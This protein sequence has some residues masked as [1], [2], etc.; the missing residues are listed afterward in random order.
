ML[1][2]NNTQ[3]MEDPYYWRNKVLS[4]KAFN[5]SKNLNSKNSSNFKWTEAN[6]KEKPQ[7]KNENQS[8][9]NKLWYREGMQIDLDSKTAMAE[10]LKNIMSH[11]KD[12][13]A[14][15][16]KSGNYDILKDITDDK[17]KLIDDQE[18][19]RI[20]ALAVSAIAEA[21]G[22][23]PDAKKILDQAGSEQLKKLKI[24]TR[25]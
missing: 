6:N 8:A 21:D 12:I 7:D 5:E 2:N 25:L 10:S 15:A 14:Q 16:K 18:E 17:A 1:N 11:I 3:I 4:W 22:H 19:I 24:T 9:L 13:I 20:K 23:A